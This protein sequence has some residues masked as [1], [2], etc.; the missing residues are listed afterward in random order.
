VLRHGAVNPATGSKSLKT[1][2]VD[3][4][5]GL[6]YDS[7]LMPVRAAVFLLFLL[8]G[9]VGLIYE[10]LWLRM[11]ILIF[12]ST[13]FA[14][15]TILTAFMAGLALGSFLFGRM[16]DRRGHPLLWYGYLEIGIG[17]YALLVP[18]LFDALVPIY[19]GI[20][21]SFAP[22]FFVFS[23]LRFFF[24]LL[25]L[26]L[27]TT[28]MGGTLPILSKFVTRRDDAIGLS[29]GS[30]YA[31]N[32]FGAVLGTA[33]SGF[34]LIPVWGT[35]GTIGIAATLSIVIGVA[36]LALG[37]AGRSA[38]AAAAGSGPPAPSVRP[39]S[40]ERMPAEARLLLW[41]LGGSGFVAMMYEIAWTRVLALII[42]SSVYAFTIMLTT[43]LV[44][45]A[46]GAAVVARLADRLRG[47]FAVE[48]LIALLTGTALAAFGTMMLF[49]ALPYQFARLYHDV[50]G[51][52]ALIFTLKYGIAFVVMLPPTLLIGGIFPLV[53]R[54]C[55]GHLS[56]LG[57]SV[58]VVY[59]SNTIGTILGSFLA[60]FFLIPMIGIQGS[61]KLAILADLALA[62]VLVWGATR[63]VR[64]MTG[65]PVARRLAGV[66]FLVMLGAGLAWATPPWDTIVM[67]SGVYQYADDMEESDLTPEG[68]QR[69][70]VEGLDLK[71]YRE[72]MTTSVMVVREQSTGVYLLAVNGKIDASS[73]GD[74]PTQLLSGHLP[75]LL[76]QDPRTALV[77]GYASGITVGAV[78]QYPVEQVTAVEIEPAI[79]EA[80]HYFDEFNHKP[81]ENPKVRVVRNDG[82][83]FL[84]VND[85]TFD[86]IISEPSN[87]W[88]TVAS[89]LFTR[90][91]FELGHRRLS[92]GGVF[93]QWLQLY[94]MSP[95]DLKVLMRTF[96][97]VFPHVLVFNTIEDADL[98][99][100]G[101]DRPLSFDLDEMKRRMSD[102]SVL[103]DLRRV[104]VYTPEDILSYFLF[105]SE[106][107]ARFTG[108]GPLNT[109]DNALIE[110]RAPKS[111]HYETRG[112]NTAALRQVTV[113]PLSYAGAREGDEARIRDGAEMVKA[114]M[115]RDM[116]SR[117]REVLAGT[118][119]LAESDEGR[120]LERLLASR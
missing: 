49:N 73:E 96:Q 87:P 25:V 53:V 117:A 13:Q 37:V 1:L 74:L 63:A 72:G 118:P 105:G 94:G 14:V 100:V 10:V 104:R 6:H 27:P 112:A 70:M 46:V 12:G 75:L 69:F 84:L 43:F 58:G 64:E 79:L 29:V 31:I 93:A 48:G 4:F 107:M 115:R 7:P 28:L 61:L 52:N 36:A 8:S 35:Q 23:L 19:R 91:F 109:D 50:R 60:G 120:E 24:V 80:S 5:C 41:V 90:E 78:T 34:V 108:P 66:A 15:S 88:M 11:L 30:L 56:R 54:A 33:I 62:L 119:G 102:L 39:G 99:L 40:P 97:S 45:L 3:P 21:E 106:E 77:I 16:I 20:W 68:F 51:Q 83:N 116:L 2:T 32:T 98:I 89:N 9:A 38:R 114:F 26:I 18:F 85:E 82:R 113:E 86:V 55:A 95:D 71:Y 44:G 103:V 47:R 67:N 17:L 101:S 22:D 111:L 110:F 65:W 57:R 59:A 42:G 81:L 76:A 92:P